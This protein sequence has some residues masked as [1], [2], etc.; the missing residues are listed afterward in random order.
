MRCAVITNETIK[1]VSQGTPRF[2]RRALWFYLAKLGFMSTFAQ[3]SRLQVFRSS[4]A[5]VLFFIFIAGAFWQLKKPALEQTKP[6]HVC[7]F[8]RIT[9]LLKSMDGE[10][11]YLLRNEQEWIEMLPAGQEWDVYRALES[12]ISYVRV[13]NHEHSLNNIYV[14]GKLSKC[15]HEIIPPNA[16]EPT[17]LYYGLPVERYVKNKRYFTLEHWYIKTPFTE[18]QSIYDS[19]DSRLVKRTALKLTDFNLHHLAEKNIHLTQ[20]DLKRYMR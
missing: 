17:S 20:T 6:V 3:S 8:E 7:N 14:T 2:R 12:S 10:G 15:V 13:A 16:Q 19:E 5:A 9:A 4:L 11:F 18:R 1:V